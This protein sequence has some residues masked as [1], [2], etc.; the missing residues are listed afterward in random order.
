MRTSPQ[1]THPMMILPT[2]SRSLVIRLVCSALVMLGTLGHF[3]LAA[4]PGTPL[5]VTSE[6]SDQK[7]GSLLVYNYYTSDSTNQNQRN[8]TLNI[9]NTSTNRSVIVHFFFVTQSCSVAD[10]KTNLTQSQTLSL[11]LSD[12]DPDVTGY[13]MAVAEN[14]EGL[15]ISHNFLIGDLYF[16]DAEKSVGLGAVGFAANW[17]AGTAIPAGTSA[18]PTV[19]IPFNGQGGGYN[20]LPA[21]VAMANFPSRA[22]GD[23]TMLILNSIGGDYSA[24]AGGGTRSVFGLLY[25]DMEQ[26]QSF[27]L[28]FTCQY[29]RTLDDS[30]PRVVPRLSTVIPSGR[31][32]WLKLYSPN[33]TQGLMGA[34]VVWNLT[35][36]VSNMGAHNLHHLT[37]TDG[38]GTTATLPVYPG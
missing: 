28:S 12:V 32:G 31:T 23:R 27:S 30:N 9:T 1:P 7:P 5:P 29:A 17:T 37:L 24:E 15:P 21:T 35:A 8:T 20:R 36:G 19:T 16:R 38:A 26:S 11:S 14:A 22:A 6:A 4:E 34:M 2:T 18:N 10:F 25:D 3:V 33:S 13:V